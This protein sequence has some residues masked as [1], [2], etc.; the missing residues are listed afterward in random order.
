MRLMLGD[1]LERM[2]ELPSASVDSVVTDPPAGISFM[3]KSWDSNR[4]G[5]D[6]FV[7][8][9]AERM[10]EAY[11]V[12]K[13]GSYAL[14]WALPRTSHWTG[15]AIED[16]GWLIHDRVSHLFGSGFPKA[17]SRLKPA[18]EDWWLAH[19]PTKGAVPLNIDACRVATTDKIKQ[20]SAKGALCGANGTGWDRPWKSNDEAVA[21]R[22]VRAQ[23]SIETAEL[24]GRWPANLVHDGSEEVLAG[25]PETKSGALRAEVQRGKFG[26]NGV[27]GESNGLGQG[28]SYS[29]DSGSAARFFY[30]AKAS[31]S[32]REEGNTHPTVKATALMRWLARLITPSG[33]TVLDPF[34]GSGSTG[35]ACALEGFDFIG[36]TDE[37]E[38]LAIAERRINAAAIRDEPDHLPMLSPPDFASVDRPAQATLFG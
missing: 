36:I 27:Y 21:A 16:G 34:M 20:P 38:H 4:G 25:F 17:D 22:L 24:L 6:R 2:P 9:L 8:W 28:R 23:A 1:C 35:K 19:K 18:M 11:R 33:G 7:G 13:P 37:A 15:L 12:A 14:V 3:G 10:A 32:D 31:K 5:R 29:V 30:C 26:K